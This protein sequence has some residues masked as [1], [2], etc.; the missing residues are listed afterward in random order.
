MS[1]ASQH[2]VSDEHQQAHE[3]RKRRRLNDNDVNPSAHAPTSITAGRE[4]CSVRQ[5]N[6]LR[7]KTE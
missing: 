4:D 3:S 5:D 6:D 7:G 2:L 1:K